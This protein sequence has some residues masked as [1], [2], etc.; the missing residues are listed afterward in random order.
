MN[1][2]AGQKFGML[3]AIKQAHKDKKGWCW[4][5]K[6]DCGNE[7]V[8]SSALNSIAIIILSLSM[9]FLISNLK[10]INDTQNEALNFI[11]TLVIEH[12]EKLGQK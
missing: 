4:L 6:C 9:L 7:K 12:E 3:T 2:I 1:K 5:F 8:M 10:K 11:T